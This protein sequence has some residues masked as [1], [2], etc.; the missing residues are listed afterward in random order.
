[1]TVITYAKLFAISEGRMT[2]PDI[3][4][5]WLGPGSRFSYIVGGKL[6]IYFSSGI[7]TFRMNAVFKDPE[8]PKKGGV[9]AIEKQFKVEATEWRRI[10]A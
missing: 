9:L 5:A 6:P 3:Q 1:M 4:F 8:Y 10:P 7:E 2:D